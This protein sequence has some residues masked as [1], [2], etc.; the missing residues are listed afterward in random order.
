LRVVLLGG[1][2]ALGPGFFGVRERPLD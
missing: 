1:A 2:V